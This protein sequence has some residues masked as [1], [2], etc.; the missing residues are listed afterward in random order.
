MIAENATTLLRS[1]LLRGERIL[2][3][4]KPRQG[5]AL[6]AADGILIPFS[7]FWGGFAIV[8][9]ALVWT[10]PFSG[11][12][13]FFKLFGLPFLVIGIYIMFGRFF[14]DAA[15]RRKLVYAV[16][17]QRVLVLKAA[18]S[19][20][21]TS[22]DLRHLSALELEEHRDGTGTISFDAGSSWLASGKYGGMDWWLPSLAAKSRF[23]RIERPRDVYS[24]IREHS[25]APLPS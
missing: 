1:Y 14:H 19:A 22:L 23:F 8:W 10:M 2:W 13:L 9:N 3:M 11:P 12:D 15:I 18:R 6:R 16:T 17:D 21:L 20:N 4:G 7:L 24:L 25:L 5:I